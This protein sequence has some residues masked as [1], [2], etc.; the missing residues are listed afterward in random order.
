MSH[1]EDSKLD[2]ILSEIGKINRGL[3]GDPVNKVSGLMQDHYEMKAEVV[4]LKDSEKKRAWM[5]AGVS[6]TLPVI[7]VWLKQKLGL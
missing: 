5:A 4:K 1:Q 6:I 7:I 2:Q 3:Y